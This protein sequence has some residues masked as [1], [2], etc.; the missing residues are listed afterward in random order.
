MALKYS[1]TEDNLSISYKIIIIFLQI[2][3]IIIRRN[4]DINY[5]IMYFI[6]NYIF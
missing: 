3:L 1:N 2:I 4:Y 5:I 6:D